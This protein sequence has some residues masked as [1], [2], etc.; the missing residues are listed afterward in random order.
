M[1]KLHT[2]QG[3]YKKAADAFAKAIAIVTKEL[4]ASHPKIGLYTNSAGEAL[5]LQK[6]YAA[7]RTSYQQAL[8]N[9]SAALGPSHPGT[10]EQRQRQTDR[11][12]QVDDGS[13]L[14]DRCMCGLHQ[15]W[16]MFGPT[17][18]RASWKRHRA[19]KLCKHSFEHGRLYVLRWVRS[20]PSFSS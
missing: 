8:A 10:C 5:Q 16:L 1:A 15:R 7:A 9:L 2:E 4:G 13:T 12:S 3:N 14:I 19:H 6:Q 20:I 18:V 11:E 17:L